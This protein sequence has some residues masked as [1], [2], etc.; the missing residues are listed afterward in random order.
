M[1][2]FEA[3]PADLRGKEEPIPAGYPLETKG[4]AGIAGIATNPNMRGEKY[5]M[6]LMRV[7]TWEIQSVGG[8]PRFPRRV[9]V[10]KH[11]TCGDSMVPSQ[12]E[13]KVLG[14]NRLFAGG[15]VPQRD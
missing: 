9:R 1:A 10:F 6:M 2:E 12:A 4:S 8:Y 11:L 5:V 13:S 14:S 7:R 3:I 15:K